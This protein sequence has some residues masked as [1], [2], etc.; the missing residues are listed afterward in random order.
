M[1]SLQLIEGGT[2]VITASFTDED[3]TAVIPT[4][5]TY[6]LLQD[7]NVVNSK[8]DVSVTPAS[9]VNIVLSGADLINGTTKIIIKGTY[10]STYGNNLPL[11]QWESFEVIDLPYEI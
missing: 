2:G 7:G 10:N 11:K 9:T 5:L 8:E 1:L 3:G 4:T 6:T